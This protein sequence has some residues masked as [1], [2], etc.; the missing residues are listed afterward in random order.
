MPNSIAT[1][2]L[3]RQVKLNPP[4]LDALYH[5]AMTF[6]SR[7]KQA[8]EA[9]K[10]TQEQIGEVTHVTKSAVS[11]WEADLTVPDVRQLAAICS[12]IG[13]SADHL[14]LGYR[15][16]ALSPEALDIAR[17]WLKLKEPRRVFYRDSLYLE[18]AIGSLYPWLTIGKPEGDGYDAWERQVERDMVERLCGVAPPPDPPQPGPAP[19]KR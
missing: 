2:N 5:S 18:A 16:E 14:I 1:L 11:Q 12:R 6:G 15:V 9:A 10:V 7:L 19:K 17:A 3:Q 8:R 4:Y 13:A